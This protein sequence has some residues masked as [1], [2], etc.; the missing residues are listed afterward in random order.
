M[1]QVVLFL[2]LNRLHESLPELPIYG[3][4]TMLLIAF[5]VTLWLAKRLAKRE[6][7]GT[8]V[9]DNIGLWLLLTG[10]LGARITFFFQPDVPKPTIG[11]FFAIWDGGLVFYGSIF[12]GLVGFLIAYVFYLRPHAISPWKLLDVLAPCIALGLAIGRVGCLLNGCC[13]GNVACAHCPEIH[14]PLPSAPREVMTSRGYQTAAGFTVVTKDAGVPYVYQVERGSEAAKHLK[15]DDRIT[16]ITLKNPD[17]PKKIDHV[18]DLASA[19][20]KEWPRGKNDLEMQVLREGVATPVGPFVP[21]GIGLHPTQIYESISMVLMTFLLL[22]YYPFKRR[23]GMVIVVLMFGYGVHRFLN[24]MLRTDTAPVAFGLTLSQNISLLIL[25]GGVVMYA[26]VRSRPQ[27]PP[28]APGDDVL[29][30]L[31]KY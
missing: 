25:I 3:Y 2:P 27:E 29:A 5:I 23:D 8:E 13:Y 21:R 14:F 19:L 24:E 20:G 6:G 7:I 4:G 18:D 11:Q 10:I 15:P 28:P 12:G 17:K 22:S 9:I 1:K 16:Q 31:A 30:R 26:V